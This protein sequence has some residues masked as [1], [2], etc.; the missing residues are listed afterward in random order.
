[1]LATHHPGLHVIDASRFVDGDRE[2][3]LARTPAGPR[4]VARVPAPAPP[5][6]DAFE[7][8]TSTSGAAV[9]LVGPLSARNAAALRRL[10]PWLAPRPLGL[11][12]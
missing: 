1:M 5:A 7:G 2:W 12:T 6:L 10:L 11:S 3:A 9:L 4:L 8:E